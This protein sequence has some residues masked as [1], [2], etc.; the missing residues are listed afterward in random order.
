MMADSS[1]RQLRLGYSHFSWIDDDFSVFSMVAQRGYGP[2]Q[3]PRIRYQ[4]LRTCLTALRHFALGNDASVHIPRI[5]CGE[6][7]GNW[8]VVQDLVLECLS[9]HGVAV[10]VY[11]LKSPH[12]A[13]PRPEQQSL[14]AHL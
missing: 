6:A 4:H 1:P 11:D 2:S 13:P 10:T 8:E 12:K 5:G 7:G 3:L 9:D 14:F